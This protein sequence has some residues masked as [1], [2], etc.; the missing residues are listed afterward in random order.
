MFIKAWEVSEQESLE[1]TELSIIL[2]LQI[3][4]KR[5]ISK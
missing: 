3:K 5:E 2:K 1:E 4:G